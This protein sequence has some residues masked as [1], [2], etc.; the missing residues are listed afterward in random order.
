MTTKAN[1]PVL[2]LTR[3]LA[4]STEFAGSAKAF[5]P[6]D[7]P[8]EILPLVK[9]EGLNVQYK[10]DPD[11]SIIFTSSNAVQLAHTNALLDQKAIYIVGQSSAEYAKTLGLN[12]S[13]VYPTA[14]ALF[15]SIPKGAYQYFR[16]Q[17][18]SVHPTDWV[19]DDVLIVESIIYRQVDLELSPENLPQGETIYVAPVFSKR[20]GERLQKIRTENMYVLA[21]SHKAASALATVVPEKLR[22]A[23]EPTRQAML[24][25]IVATLKDLSS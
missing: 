10:T 23:S 24:E 6:K 7:Q 13:G 18:I 1:S 20:A 22:I 11:A 2:L 15:E 14:R 16:G 12:V 8:I 17:D 25:L 5:L 4:Q 19:S 9:I 21:I 3:S